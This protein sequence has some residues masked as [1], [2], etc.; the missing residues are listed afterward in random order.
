MNGNFWGDGG[1]TLPGRGRKASGGMNLWTAISHPSEGKRRETSAALPAER[2]SR[3]PAEAGLAQKKEEGEQLFQGIALVGRDLKRPSGP[4]F[5]GKGS[6]KEIISRP[7]LLWPFLISSIIII[8]SS[9]VNIHSCFGLNTL[10]PV[11]KTQSGKNDRR[12]KKK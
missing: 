5:P 8:S 12:K 4:T 7:V 2:E 3:E 11:Q 1:N 6:L 10:L 9:T